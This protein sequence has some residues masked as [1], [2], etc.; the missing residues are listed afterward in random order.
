MRVRL[1]PGEKRLC[2]DQGKIYEVVSIEHN[3]R[4]Y[5]IVDESGEAYLYSAKSFEIVEE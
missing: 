5:A 4:L 3:G 1:L 2:L